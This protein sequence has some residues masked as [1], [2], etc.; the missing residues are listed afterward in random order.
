MLSIWLKMGERLAIERS[1]LQDD[2]GGKRSILSSP[3]GNFVHMPIPSTT[4]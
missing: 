1:S 4:Y 3:R 2:S